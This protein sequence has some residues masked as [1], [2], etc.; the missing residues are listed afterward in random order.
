MNGVVVKVEK[1]DSTDLPFINQ[2]H[3]SLWDDDQIK[4]ENDIS[5]APPVINTISS[6]IN[7]PSF[8][9]NA[10]TD[11]ITKVA[12]INQFPSKQTMCEENLEKG[13]SDI[14]TQDAM[15][16]SDTDYTG[17]RTAKGIQKVTP[18]CKLSACSYSLFHI[19]VSWWCMSNVLPS[20]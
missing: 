16:E 19:L 11:V 5:Y 7:K 10:I 4:V 1:L 3:A 20:T 9:T 6:D 14:E 17:G 13:R 12:S 2:L 8:P 15:E 18:C